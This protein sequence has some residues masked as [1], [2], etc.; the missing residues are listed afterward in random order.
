MEFS[1]VVYV[2]APLIVFAGYVV[3]GISGF[4]ATI[5]MVP[6]LA[7][8]L[9]I[10]FVVPLALLLDLGA[11]ILMRANKGGQGRNSEEI[12]WILPFM[13]AG[14]ALGAYLLTAA[15]ERW[16]MFALGAFVAGYAT[17][18]LVRGKGSAGNIARWWGAPISVIGGIGSSLFGTGGPV[19]AIYVTRRMHDPGEMR[20]TMST[21]IAISVVVR[22]VIFSVAGLLLKP[23][24]GIAWVGLCLFM[25]SG[26]LLGM[27]LHSRMKPDDVRRVVH[28]LLVVSGS[29]L[30][31][32]ALSMAG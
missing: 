29:S 19:Y 21:I 26:L 20:A 23:E 8:F 4:G 31:L 12:R 15:P 1:P 7:H 17:L 9:P 32:R 14:M 18:S 24:L 30:V 27:R 22:L 2:V 6:V 13:F 5:V 28:V 16:L 25:G 11:A 10:K 3:F